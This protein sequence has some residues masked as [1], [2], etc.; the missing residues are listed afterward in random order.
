MHKIRSEYNVWS[1]YE[2]RIWLDIICY[3]FTGLEQCCSTC[4]ADVFTRW[5]HHLDL[6]NWWSVRNQQH[7]F[8][9]ILWYCRITSKD[10]FLH[11]VKYLPVNHRHLYNNWWVSEVWNLMN[12]SAFITM[13]NID[14]CLVMITTMMMAINFN[15]LIILLLGL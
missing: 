11:G 14:S 8:A 15:K 7:P 12:I 3:V 5:W 13:I 9:S 4:C 2:Q 10:E 1:M 6:I